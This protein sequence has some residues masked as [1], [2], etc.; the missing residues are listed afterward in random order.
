M[1]KKP[2]EGAKYVR[3]SVGIIYCFS[4]STTICELRLKGAYVIFFKSSKIG[5]KREPEKDEIKTEFHLMKRSLGRQVL[6]EEAQNQLAF[7]YFKHSFLSQ[8]SSIEQIIP[9]TAT[10][11]PLV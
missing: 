2:N 6:K 1:Y 11:I 4:Y 3:V 9:K 8:F 5:L 7:L 10:G